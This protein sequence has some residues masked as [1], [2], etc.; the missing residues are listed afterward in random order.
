[1]EWKIDEARN[2][3]KTLMLNGKYIYSKY[4]PQ[5]DVEK[6]L[7][8]EIKPFS[9]KFL[10]IGVGI[11]YHIDYIL[12][13]IPN[14]EV[15]YI[16]LDEKEKSFCKKDILKHTGVKCY[17]PNQSIDKD[18]QIIIP[19]A[20]L[21]ALNDTHPLFSFIEDIKIRQVS[22][23]RFKEQMAENFY[24]NIKL[25]APLQKI[26]TC[27]RKA[28]LVASG[29]SLNKTVYWL[30]QHTHEFDIYCVGSALKILLK[31]Q[32]FPKK[33]FIIDA[34]DTMIQQV[35][36]EYDGELVFLSTANF[37]AVQKHCGPKQIIFQEGY[38]LAEAFAIKNDQ[39]LFETGGS[40][41]TTAFS[42]IEW[43]GYDIVYLFGQ[44]LGF[45]E[46]QTHAS[47]STSGR[48]VMGK[49]KLMKVLANDGM[50][51]FTTKNLLAYKRWFDKK[52]EKTKLKVYNTAKKGAY[53]KGTVFF[54]TTQR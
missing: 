16:L 50:D 40:V 26:N 41:A 30:K 15:Q 20:F 21:N 17:K 8:N 19:Q 25:Y 28:A 34:Q 3:Q 23:E 27:S 10:M 38:D 48:E 11:G 32:I 6:F 37:K 22:Y 31:E 45:S 18:V 54:D 43:V 24:E 47:H 44:D 36:E 12:K 52:C 49:E 42:Y 46:K 29:P 5:K 53:I 4:N 1:M 7:E 9:K 51:I 39:P 13:N 2:G 33:V 14:A 35:T